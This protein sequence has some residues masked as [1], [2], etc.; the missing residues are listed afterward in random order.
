MNHS[1]NAAEEFI[2]YFKS[3]GEGTSWKALNF[4]HYLLAGVPF[5]ENSNLYNSIH[6]N[7]LS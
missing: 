1:K 3:G 5:M 2:G 6:D 7:L 4:L